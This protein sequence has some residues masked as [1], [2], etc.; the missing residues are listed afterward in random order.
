MGRYS[1]RGCVRPCK[2]NMTRH[3]RII[4]FNRVFHYK[5][6][7]FWGIHFCKFYQVV[8]TQIFFISPRIPGEMIQ[9]DEYF[10]GGLKPPTRWYTNISLDILDLQN[11]W[12]FSWICIFLHK[13]SY[14]RIATWAGMQ[15][16]VLHHNVLSK[17]AI[18]D[19][20]WI[21]M[22]I[23]NWKRTF[24]WVEKTNALGVLN[25]KKLFAIHTVF[26]LRKVNITIELPFFPIEK[27]DT[28]Y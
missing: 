10:S 5:P 28:V 21:R 16:A 7:P 11:M 13:G 24:F 12:V 25:I 2:K 6:K 26:T 23:G 18:S 1:H 8:A 22:N 4:H 3:P 27:L 20:G 15:V 17:V 19:C 9:F 14:R